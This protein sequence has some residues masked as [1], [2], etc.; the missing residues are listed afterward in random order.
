MLLKCLIRQTLET[1]FPASETDEFLFY[2]SLVQ[3]AEIKQH[4]SVSKV[5]SSP[6]F[7]FVLSWPSLSCADGFMHVRD[8]QSQ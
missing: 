8:K 4:P 7:V 3:T 1:R 2:L 6:V 5:N